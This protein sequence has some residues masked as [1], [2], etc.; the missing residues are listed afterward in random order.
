MEQKTKSIPV[1]ESEQEKEAIENVEFYS[2]CV[3]NYIKDNALTGPLRSDVNHLVIWSTFLVR[4]F[5]ELQAEVERSHRRI[6]SLIEQIYEKVVQI[7]RM[8]KERTKIKEAFQDYANHR[9][10]KGSA[11]LKIRTWNK[12]NFAITDSKI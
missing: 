10:D 11:T 12:L 1:K 2:A 8:D 6:E 3:S 5:K 9:K 7:E 4:D